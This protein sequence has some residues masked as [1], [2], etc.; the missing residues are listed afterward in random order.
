MPPHLEFISN[1]SVL[2]ALRHMNEFRKKKITSQFISSAKISIT[3]AHFHIGAPKIPGILTARKI[4][5]T[6]GKGVTKLPKNSIPVM[7][8]G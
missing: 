1:E 4:S 3:T 5:R 7:A 8:R 6:N 2:G